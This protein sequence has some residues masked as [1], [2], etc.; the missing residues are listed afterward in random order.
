M[1]KL[2]L[3]VMVGEIESLRAAVSG[4]AD[5]I[6]LCSHPSGGGLTPSPGYFQTVKRM[7]TLP[8]HVLI[9]PHTGGFCYTDE[10]IAC[11]EKDVMYFRENGADGIVCGFLNENYMVNEK[12]TRRFVELAGPLAFTFHRAI[13]DCTDMMEGTQRAI[14]AGCTRILTSGGK[15]NASEGIRT[16]EKMLNAHADEII[17]MPGSGVNAQNIRLFIDAGAKEFHSSAGKHI[18]SP[19]R[20]PE[21]LFHR[22][23]RKVT[24]EVSVRA[25]RSVLD[26]HQ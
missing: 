22:K 12:L 5:R 24:D 15:A 23:Q 19:E 26:Q 7:T 2:N 25:I 3:E 8:V 17:I 14:A 20:F 21:P 18:V 1:S 16:I 9:R 6:E 11:M 13:D 4:G 10:E